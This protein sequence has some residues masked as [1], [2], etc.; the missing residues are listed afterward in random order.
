MDEKSLLK[1]AKGLKYTVKDRKNLINKAYR[2][3]GLTYLVAA[4]EEIGE[5]I[6]VI[7]STCMDM[8]LNY[9]HMAEEINDVY[10][11]VSIIKTVFDIKEKDIKTKNFKKGIDKIK[12]INSK[13]SYNKHYA[14][15]MMEY[16]NTLSLD[17]KV[18]CKYL[19]GKDIN[20]E[21]IIK[22]IND[23][24]QINYNLVEAFDIKKSDLNRIALL[25]Y[26]RLEDRLNSSTPLTKI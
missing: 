25:K 19:R 24:N 4:I 13:S 11:A 26:K 2:H 15:T 22:L 5:L 14:K 9:I 18:I 10:Y 12:S 7:S 17:S 21:D 1:S 8:K 23:L 6:D 16:I 20:K 3:L